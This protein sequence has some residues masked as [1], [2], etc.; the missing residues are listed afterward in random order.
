MEEVHPLAQLI[1]QASIRARADGEAAEETRDGDGRRALDVVVVPARAAAA[2][3]AW[4]VGNAA[5]H[6]CTERSVTS[7][8]S[9]VRSDSQPALGA[10]AHVRNLS[11]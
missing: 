11:R 9:R 1:E 6:A 10:C 8:A 5:T 2:G 3:R 4:W 7:I